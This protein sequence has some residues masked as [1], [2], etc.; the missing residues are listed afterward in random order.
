MSDYATK[1]LWEALYSLVG[2]GPIQSRLAGAAMNLIK[3][4][5]ED[6]P[7]EH[8]AAY[9]GLRNELTH[10]EPEEG[11]GSIQVSTRRLSDDEGEAIAIR[12]LEL[13]T[14]LRDGI[15]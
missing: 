6:F 14:A 1:V 2:A 7:E 5:G 8:R 10:R 12:I 4:N 3:L 11:E 9:S 13:Y 15:S